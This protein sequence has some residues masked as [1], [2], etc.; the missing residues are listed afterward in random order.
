MLEVMYVSLASTVLR[1]LGP[2]SVQDELPEKQPWPA[3][4]ELP[5]GEPQ[6]APGRA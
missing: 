3:P 5:A 2:A 6:P 4:E 1:R